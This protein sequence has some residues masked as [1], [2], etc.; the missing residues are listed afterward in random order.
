MAI[1]QQLLDMAKPKLL[2]GIV[3]KL[4]S[5]EFKSMRPPS[6]I[7]EVN[8]KELKMELDRLMIRHWGLPAL[9]L[10][11]I[12]LG[13]NY[14][15]DFYQSWKGTE[16]GII[17]YVERRK[18]NYGDDYFE[19]TTNKVAVDNF[20]DIGDDLVLSFEEYLKNFRYL[21]ERIGGS[22]LGFDILRISLILIGLFLPVYFFIRF[23]RLAPLVIDR[24]KG[25][26][27]TWRGGRVLA[28]RYEDMQYLGNI[29]GLFIPLGIIPN[30][31]RFREKTIPKDAVGWAPFRIMPNGN[32]YVNDMEEYEAILAYIVQFMEYGREHVLPNQSS[33]QS[34]KKDYL[35][36]KDKKPDDFDA[37]LKEV[38][39]RLEC[40]REA[41][42]KDLK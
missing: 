16:R 30:R 20:N 5:F 1:K 19:V 29:Q 32:L 39:R 27:Y 4:L 37:Q 18:K 40:N 17:S 2:T 7:I 14:T 38:L 25:L 9:F 22:E 33:W 35:L 31:R 34:D 6:P 8:D 11:F 3:S 36:Y 26:L 24:D 28:Q 41:W 42:L 13:Y 15:H 10:T 12:F 23:K 21:P